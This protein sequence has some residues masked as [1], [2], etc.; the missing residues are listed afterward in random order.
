MTASFVLSAAVALRKQLLCALLAALACAGCAPGLSANDT[1]Y[2][3]TERGFFRLGPH[4][5]YLKDPGRKLELADVLQ[6][7]QDFQPV[8]GAYAAFGI[9]RDAV[10]LRFTMRPDPDQI[11]AWNLELAT[12]SLSEARLYRL[13]KPGQGD[14]GNTKPVVIRTRMHVTDRPYAHHNCVFP[15]GEIESTETVY[16]RLVTNGAM[17]VP[18]FL[19]T[20][21]SFPMWDMLRTFGYG[22]FFGLMLV[23]ALY[24]SFLFISIRDKAYLYYVLYIV[25]VTLFFAAVSGHIFYLLPRDRLHWIEFIGPPLS[26]LAATLALQFS[27][28]FLLVRDQLPGASRFIDFVL[29]LNAASLLAMLFVS[30]FVM[31]ML[32]NTIPLISILTLLVCAIKLIRRGFRPAYYFLL[33]WS[34]L[35]VGAVLFVL[36]NLGAIPSGFTTQY[37][38]FIGAGLEA[39]LLS[40]ALGY[41]IN[42]LKEADAESRRRLLEEQAAALENERAMSESFARFVPAEFLDFLGK[43]SVTQI[44]RGDVVRKDMAVLFLDIRG[45]TGLS[46]RLGPEATFAFLNEFHGLLEPVIQRHGGFI[47]KFI[48]DAIMAL[49]PDPAGSVRAAVAMQAAV[50]SVPELEAKFG[51][52]RIGVGVHYGDVMLGT[53]GS[54]RRLETTVIGDTVNVASRIEGVNKTYGSDV[55]IS[56]AVYKFVREDSELLT[57]ELDAIRVRGKTRPIVLYEIYNS[58]EAAERE[59]RARKLPD[60]MSALLAYRAGDFSAAHAAFKEYLSEPDFADGAAKIYLSRLERLLAAPPEDWDGVWRGS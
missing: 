53:V 10:W 9:T 17:N 51:K 31:V 3:Q 55:V 13:G 35:I 7:S 28:R 1:A 34:A 8:G 60:F 48:G 2:L 45:F 37:S 20:S 39:V 22:I 24:N 58:L 40:L 33:A 36:Q 16:L 54:P 12:S 52:T 32:A 41:R 56:D 14:P 21:S 19:W 43:A 59:R 27:R 5:Q 18:A 42:L 29:V 11:Q 50:R 38:L 26:L 47:D 49:F 46:E 30:S 15:F 6:R 44:A 4:M 25:A 23:M 57:R